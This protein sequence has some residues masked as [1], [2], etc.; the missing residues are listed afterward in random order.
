MK[1]DDLLDGEDCLYSIGQNFHRMLSGVRV[2]ESRTFEHVRI[3]DMK[4][5]IAKNSE[6][7]KMFTPNNFQ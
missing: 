6:E 2:L 3:S 4:Q 5:T 1:I 7:T